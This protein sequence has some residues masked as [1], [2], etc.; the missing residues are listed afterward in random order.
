MVGEAERR[1]QEAVAG[2]AATPATQPKFEAM[3][4]ECVCGVRTAHCCWQT[5][6]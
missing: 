2:G 1:Y 4:L 3:D 6:P 5:L